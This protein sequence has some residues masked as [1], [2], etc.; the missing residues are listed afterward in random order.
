[1][2]VKSIAHQKYVGPRALFDPYYTPPE[3]IGLNKERHSMQSL[4][5]DA[6]RDQY[7][8]ILSLYGLRGVGKTALTR[9]V[10]TNLQKSNL[11]STQKLEI[12]YVNCEEK[13][14]SQILYSLINGLSRSQHFDLSPDAILNTSL[15][16]QINLLNHLISKSVGSDSSLLFYLDSIEHS[17][18]NF[19][20]KIM[21]VSISQSCMMVGSFN[22]LKSSPYLTDFKKSDIQ[23]QLNTYNPASLE[24]I[25]R[26][27]CKLAFKHPVEPDVIRYMI[28]LVYSYDY[29][30]PES[31]ICVLRKLYPILESDSTMTPE[32]IQDICRIQLKDYSI[33]E[34][35]I[36]EFISE[37]DMVDRIALDEISS[38]FKSQSRYYTTYSELGSM[39]KIACENL[40]YDFI[41]SHFQF[42]VSKLER[43][44]LLQPSTFHPR[45]HNYSTRTNQNSVTR[46]YF[47]TISPQVFS[48]ILDVSFGVVPFDSYD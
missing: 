2:L 39:Y 15:A 10:I 34:I 41:Q 23:I 24:R 43:I 28:D 44:G 17:Q 3:L 35:Y 13:E 29:C 4:L 6:I 31:C 36:A 8:I 11:K 33:D 20:N 48:D 40:K 21:D 37:T 16:S 19:I 12:Y 1:M 9:K 42:F 7:P 47:L 38:F 18:P 46:L 32:C 14:S 30:V 22:V 45:S 5:Q 25:S 26:D 27:R